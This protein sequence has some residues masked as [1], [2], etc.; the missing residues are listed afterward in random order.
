M[1]IDL[2]QTKIEREMLPLTNKQKEEIIAQLLSTEE[3]RQLLI[4]ATEPRRCPKIS[5]TDADQYICR[6]G[7]LDGLIIEV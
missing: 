5:G 4:G 2:T 6:H 3:G 1:I 7:S